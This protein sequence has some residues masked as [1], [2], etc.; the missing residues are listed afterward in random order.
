M[1]NMAKEGGLGSQL[2]VP[3]RIG[4]GGLAT[5]LIVMP[6]LPAFAMDMFSPS[7]PSMTVEFNTTPSEMT[8]TITLFFFLFALGMI[9][10]G[11]MSDKYGR[12]PL[13]FLCMGLFT[14]GSALCAFASSLGLLIAFRMVEALGAGGDV[15]QSGRIVLAPPVAVEA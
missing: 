12:K 3:Q 11:T 8:L 5:L 15:L 2:L 10:F 7:I 14:L 6:S 13:L 4:F 1:G 9:V